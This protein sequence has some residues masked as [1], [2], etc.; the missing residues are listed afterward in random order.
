M[1]KAMNCPQDI[2]ESLQL[3]VEH[4]VPPGDFLYAVLTNNLRES[5]GRADDENRAA[6]FEIV[7]Y[8]WNHIPSVCWGS[9]ARVS[10]WLNPTK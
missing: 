9:P 5:F 7:A 8:C 10:E 6:L 4:R 2:Q 3:Y 1:Q